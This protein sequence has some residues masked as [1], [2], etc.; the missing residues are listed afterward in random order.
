M[1]GNRLARQ[2]MIANPENIS[3]NLLMGEKAEMAEYIDEA[4]WLFKKAVEFSPTNYDLNARLAQ[5]YRDQYDR[6]DDPRF[7][8]KAVEYFEQAILYAPNVASIQKA[9]SELKGK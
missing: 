4:E 8:T 5:F 6:S 9:Y 3:G 1:L 2:F 7:R